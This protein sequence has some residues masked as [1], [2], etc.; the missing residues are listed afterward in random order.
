[1][2]IVVGAVWF[3]LF[4]SKPA[5]QQTVVEETVKEL[6]LEQRPYITLTPTTDG[7]TL[8]FTI[9]NI[10]SGASAIDY[11]LGYKTADGVNEGVTGYIKL[12]GERQIDR[13]LLLGSCSS[14]KCRYHE[15][16]ELGTITIK[17][18]DSNG[19]LMGQAISDFHL[20]NSVSELTLP[21][22]GF[23][24]T[25]GGTM[26]KGYAITM[27]TLGLPG[28]APGSVMAGPVGVF[29]SDKSV[30]AKSVSLNGSGDLY[31]WNGSSWV[32]SEAKPS[33]GTFVKVS[34]Q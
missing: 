29:A 24:A 23:S 5:E 30:S 22:A 12:K 6:P 28:K 34:S 14:G 4:R 25:L 15:G 18:Q 32:K 9:S 16:V 19:K 2:A 33:L 7:H 13:D 20:Q 1:M 26:K 17:L 11:E 10:T 27:G 3:F 8:H 21:K 31:N